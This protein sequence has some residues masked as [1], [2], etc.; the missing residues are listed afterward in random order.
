LGSTDEVAAA[1]TWLASSASYT[2]GAI[3]TV[4]GGKGARGA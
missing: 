1:V 2:T 3:L 4:D